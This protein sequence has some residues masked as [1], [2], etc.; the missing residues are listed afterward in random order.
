MIK[1]LIHSPVVMGL[2]IV[3]LVLIVMGLF[4]WVSLSDLPSIDALKNYQP[5][6]STVV[7]DRN[8]AIVG[9]FY[10]ERRTVVSLKK[11]PPQVKNAFIAAEDADFFEHRGIDYF[12]LMR[13]VLLEIKYRLIGGR[14]VG[15]S[16]ITQQTARTMLLT[17]KQTYVRKLQEIVLAQRIEE[18]LSKEA[19]LHLYLNQI[20]F[21]NGAYGIE[22]AAQ[23][24]FKKPAAKLTLFE[25]AA[26]AS[27]PKSPNRINP[28]SDARRLKERQD[29]VLDQMVKHAF[30]SE[31]EAAKA[32]TAPLFSDVAENSS[33]F[34]QYFLRAVKTELLTKASDEVIRRGGMRVYSTLDIS[35]QK[36]AEAALARGLRSLDKRGGYRG[37]IVRLNKSDHGTLKEYLDHFKNRAFIADNKHKVWDLSRITAGLV[38][39]SIDSVI[40]NIR[41]VRPTTNPMVGA[42]VIT[43]NEQAQTATIDLGSRTVTMNLAQASW[44][45]KGKKTWSDL[46]HT[47]DIV[48]VQIR[49]EDNK[50]IATL[51]QEPQINGGLVAL[52][53]ATGSVLAMAGGYDFERSPFN[54]ITQAKRQ[55]GS[56]LK[57]LIYALALEDRVVTPV[58]LITDAPKAFL[59]P[60]TNEFWKPRNWT[61]KYLGDITFRHCLRASI[62]TC[63]I[64]LLEKIGIERFMKF[65]EAVELS[66]KATPYPRNLTIALGSAE[67]HPIN[68]ANA[69]RILPNR[70]TYSPYYMIDS[71]KHSDGKREKLY[72]PKETQVLSPAATYVITNILQEVV[73]EAKR[74]NHL[75]N[76]KSQIAGKTGTTNKARSTW[77]FGYS[78]KIL[79]LVYVGYDDNRSIGE[80]AYGIN[81]AFEPWAEFMNGISENQE[82]MSF[83][84]PNTIEWRYVDR[85]NGRIT[86]APDSENASSVMMEAFIAGTAPDNAVINS[87]PTTAPKILDEAAFAP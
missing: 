81:T 17:A 6:Q 24:Y 5:P 57:A 75:P 22:E 55:P 69:M 50:T 86:T 13:A 58:S 46:L 38:N 42:Q 15:G 23:T 80:D 20:Y 66:T 82:P 21:G 3:S 27:I 78:P 28:F 61:N 36:K 49:S 79:A 19:I 72:E 35:M 76:V 83:A 34:A 60:G 70:G 47:G 39:Q 9:R 45:R 2:S 54:R 40:D 43:V 74:N 64:T 14:R 67:S 63:T 33:Q 73:S 11:I 77:F 68:V 65:A 37:P 1:K 12:G 44:A 7:L 29:Y 18:A 53:V 30:I 4:V 26:L 62:N 32:K 10:D 31:Q 16:T 59:D 52:D 41:L 48:L 87:G 8:G 85:N 56:G 84:I 25:A 51:E 71:I